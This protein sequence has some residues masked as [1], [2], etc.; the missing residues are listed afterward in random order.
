MSK[1]NF[2]KEKNKFDAHNDL[3]E[4]ILE[5]SY[6]KTKNL[7]YKAMLIENRIHGKIVNFIEIGDDDLK[8]ELAYTV[9]ILEQ[10]D[11]SVDD[12]MQKGNLNKDD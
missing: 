11:K 6:E 2:E 7:K 5:L 4:M 1:F 9:N 10:L 3:M 8:E 12:I